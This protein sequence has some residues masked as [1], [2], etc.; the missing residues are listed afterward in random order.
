MVY[1]YQ[2]PPLADQ[3]CPQG[4]KYRAENFNPPKLCL[5]EPSWAIERG[6]Y[7]LGVYWSCLTSTQGLKVVLPLD[8][9]PLGQVVAST[10]W[11]GECPDMVSMS[12]HE[13]QGNF[14]RWATTGVDTPQVWY[15]PEL[16]MNH[17]SVWK[18]S[19][20]MIEWTPGDMGI[21]EWTPNHQLWQVCD[22]GKHGYKCEWIVMSPLP[23]LTLSLVNTEVAT[24]RFVVG[25]FK[26]GYTS[27][28]MNNGIVRPFS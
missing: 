12:K 9:Y 3:P 5:P 23:R 27:G 26:M 14:W 18:I 25:C 6:P 7:E 10:M 2:Y 13:R 8:D 24:R 1:C 20:M 16:G 19:Y 21:D 17:S 22:A 28:R 4:C 11:M 15:A